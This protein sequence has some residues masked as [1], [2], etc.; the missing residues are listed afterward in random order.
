MSYRKADG[1][2]DVRFNDLPIQYQANVAVRPPFTPLPG[3]RLTPAEAQDLIT[4]L[5]TFTDGFDPRNPGAYRQ[6]KQCSNAVR[7]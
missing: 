1:Q 2:P 7:R 5:C 4:Y 6:S 3:G